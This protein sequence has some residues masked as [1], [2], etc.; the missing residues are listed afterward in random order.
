MHLLKWKHQPSHQGKNGMLTMKEQRRK[1][2]R[3][4]DKS[5]S[6]KRELPDMAIEAYGDAVLSAARETGFDE[7]EFPQQ[8]PWTLADALR[9][10]FLPE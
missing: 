10:D 1:I 9:E 4:I 8:M 6:L 2:A 5:P 7:K 3:R